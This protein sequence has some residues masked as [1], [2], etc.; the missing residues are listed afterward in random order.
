MARYDMPLIDPP[1]AFVTAAHIDAAEDFAILVQREAGC[2]T[3]TCPDLTQCE[4]GGMVCPRH[5]PAAADCVTD[6]GVH[7]QRCVD[8]CE[9]C[10]RERQLDAAA[11]AG[12]TI[13]GWR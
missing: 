12:F 1:E 7:H 3:A 4:C 8:G 11:D 13:G 10:A 6:A 2:P 9:D 5:T